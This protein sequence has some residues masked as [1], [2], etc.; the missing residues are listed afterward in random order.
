MSIKRK[1]NSHPDI[2][3]VTKKT[4]GS[5]PDGFWYRIRR[6]WNHRVFHPRC[7]KGSDAT[8]GR[9]TREPGSLALCHSD[10]KWMQGIPIAIAGCYQRFSGDDHAA[11]SLFGWKPRS[12]AII[13]PDIN[14]HS[15]WISLG[16]RSFRIAYSASGSKFTRNLVGFPMR[17]KLINYYS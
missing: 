14:N 1:I 2:P 10:G 12:K 6:H 11:R 9:G 3:I 5:H 17:E 8:C 13:S 16:L 15:N 4:R 7:R